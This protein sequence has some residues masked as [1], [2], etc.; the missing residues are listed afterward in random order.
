MEPTLHLHEFFVEGSNPEM[1]HVLLNITEPSTPAEKSKGYFFAI[2]EINNATTKYIARMQGVIDEIENN[3]YET[4][5]QIGQTATEIDQDKINRENLPMAQPDISLHCIVG[6][7]RENDIIFSFHGHPQMVLFYK[8]KDE[9]YKKMDLVEQNVPAADTPDKNQLFS[10]IVQGKIGPDDFFFAG[11]PHIIEYFNHDRLQKI[12]TTRPPRQ[13]S[14]HLQRVLSEIKNNLSFGGIIINL[15][16]GANLPVS[17]KSSPA[18]KGGAGRSLE[19]LFSTEQNTAHILSPSFLPRFQDKTE[20]SNQEDAVSVSMMSGAD[21]RANAEITSSHLRARTGKAK[22]IIEEKMNVQDVVKKT[23]AIIWK[24]LKYAA[25]GLVLLLLFI[26]TIISTLGRNFLLLFFIITNYQNRRHNILAQ[27]ARWWKNLKE[28]AKH[29]PLVTKIL[30]SLSLIL[31]LA[32][33]AGIMYMGAKQ[34]KEARASAY[35][36]AVQNIKT[37]EDAA[38]SS[39]VY[40]DTVAALANIKEAEQVIKQLSCATALEKSNCKNLQDRL[41]GLLMKARKIVLAHPQLVANWNNLAQNIQVNNIFLLNNKIY[42]FGQTSADI[43]TYDPLVKESKLVTP[44]IF[45]KNFNA[46]SVPKENDYAVLLYDDKNIVQFNP[47]D[48]AWKKVDIDYPNQNM[49]IANISVYNR[50]LY[51]LDTQNNQVYKHDAIKT[52]FSQGK[53][54]TKNNATDIKTGIDL[55]IDGDVFVLGKN[56]VVYKFTNGIAGPFTITGLDPELKSA[57]EIWTYNDLN[58][59]YILDATGKRIIILDK[60]G[61]LKTQVTATEF[62]H[63]TGMIVDEQ[64]STAYILDSNKLYQISL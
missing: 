49:T 54:W 51:S 63:P 31:L 60:T 29:L 7:I 48:N 64:K 1:S 16:P 3:Y 12:I 34:K 52:G 41:D 32:F 2:C 33:S 13:S 23:L 26:S 21:S 8:T 17:L 24:I 39:L 58:Y 14:E 10:Q 47:K 6:A 36:K 50:K 57:N 9:F 4:P 20:S 53:E 30:L 42:G 59:I 5:D 28:N 27:W 45:V 25:R 19:N 43:L 38:E 61:Q 46:A 55:T 56:G 35:V 40:N 18:R 15:Q 37:K 22:K 44:G 11:T 62:I